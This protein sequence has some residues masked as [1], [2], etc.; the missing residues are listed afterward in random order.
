MGVGLLAVP[1]AGGADAD[2]LNKLCLTL[3]TLNLIL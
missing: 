2:V 3:I 1:A